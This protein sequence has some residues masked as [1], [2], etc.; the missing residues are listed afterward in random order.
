MQTNG[1]I[2]YHEISRTP[3][4]AST[5][6]TFRKVKF[7]LL[8]HSIYSTGLNSSDY[9]IPGP[10]KDALHGRHFAKDEDVK[11]AGYT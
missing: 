3:T 8:S 5:I 7:E 2:L 11:D 6:E 9:L 4:V 1:I 10:L